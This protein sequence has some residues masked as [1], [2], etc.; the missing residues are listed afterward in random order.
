ME[1]DIVVEPSSGT[2][3]SAIGGL[4][5]ENCVE[6][7][8]FV[9]ED[10]FD[11]RQT[12]QQLETIRKAALELS[13]KLT[14]DYIWQRD[15]FRVELKNANGLLYL[16]GI[17]DYGD[18]VEDEWLV[19]YMLRELTKS[20]PNLWIRAADSDGE[21]LLIEA[22]N[23]LPKWLNPEIDH[24]RVWIHGG[25]LLIIPLDNTSKV[26]APDSKSRLL[27]LPQAIHFL[28]SNADTLVHSDSIQSESFYRLEKYPGY[29]TNSMHYSLVTVPRKL[30]YILHSCPKSVAPAVEYFYLRDP[31]ALKPI[32]SPSGPPVFYPKDLVTISVQFSK[33]LFAQLR[34]QQFDAPPSWQS[35]LPNAPNGEA[36]S[37]DQ[38]RQRDMLD[39]GMKLTSGFEMLSI[40]AEKNKSRVVREM[41]IILE[42][43]EED[44]EEA[45]PSDKDMESWENVCRND[46][47]SWL[48]INYGDFEREL[49]GTQAHD[50]EQA[51]SG[52]GDAQTQENLRKIVSR[53]E[54]FLKDDDA[55]LDGAELDSEGSDDE[56][57]EEEGEGEEEDSDIEDK[58]VNF[59]EETF[60]RLMREIMGQPEKHS[61]Q[62]STG[63]RSNVEEQRHEDDN[64]TTSGYNEEREIQELSSQMEAELKQFG[65]LKLDAQPARP[66]IK[67]N[68]ESRQ[69]KG[70]SSLDSENEEVE[71]DSDE[72]IDIDYNLA[73]NLLES[74]KGQGG[75]AG[76]AGNLMG[77]MGFQ[78]P[79]DE[80]GGSDS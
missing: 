69:Q 31:I 40:N 8:L 42:D 12:R 33:V 65:A 53:F 76:P 1:E 79:R 22:A 64:S 7:L 56:D 63:F 75:M 11:V 35:I 52:F 39:I 62:S 18:A 19:V 36:S 59:D 66:A 2:A 10:Q 9:L 74:F 71:E 47:E 13:Q 30:A 25:K 48:D 17:T 70:E 38:S 57:E 29:I 26:V 15:E 24:C 44:G 78:L 37:D 60:A 50:Q 46:D 72:E 41:A 51:A 73:K 4:L 32:L 61:D 21:F 55:G 23:A 45:L 5:P 3:N 67:N 28:K 14:K 16:Y 20:Y 34:S 80:D 27:S 54:T 68:T 58:E 6:Y 49:E 43:L 77:L